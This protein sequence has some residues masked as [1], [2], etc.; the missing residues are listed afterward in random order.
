[1]GVTRNIT[2]LSIRKNSEILSEVVIKVFCVKV[3]CEKYNAYCVHIVAESAPG[4]QVTLKASEYSQMENELYEWFQKQGPKHFKEKPSLNASNG[5][6]PK[7]KK[8]HSIRMI[9][10]CL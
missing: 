8:R 6:I 9:M 1:M 7:F 10:L 2:K 5:W 4:K 3:L